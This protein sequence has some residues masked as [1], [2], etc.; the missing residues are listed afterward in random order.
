MSRLSPS[1]Q[2]VK[3]IGKSLEDRRRNVRMC[4]VMRRVIPDGLE[5]S[6]PGCG[7]GVFAAGPRDQPVAEVG[8]EPTILH[9]A[10][11]LAALPL[12]VLGHCR[13]RFTLAEYQRARNASG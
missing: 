4:S 13:W 1:S 9:Q 11:D 7:P 2:G 12:C 10:L 3:V 8:V 5:P 6:L